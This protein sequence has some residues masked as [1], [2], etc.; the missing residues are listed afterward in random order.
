MPEDYFSQ[1]SD[2]EIINAELWMK[3]QLIDY[4]CYQFEQNQIILNDLENRNAT[5]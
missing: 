4:N 2:S 3:I 1:F 5:V